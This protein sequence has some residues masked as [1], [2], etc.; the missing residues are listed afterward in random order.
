M[1]IFYSIFTFIIKKLFFTFVFFYI[2]SSNIYSQNQNLVDSLESIYTTGNFDEPD[3]LKI[4][5]ELSKNHFDP[6]KRIIYSE[7][8]IKTARNTDSLNY[9]FN[10][11]LQKGNAYR[12][13]GD[14]KKA[15]VDY[16]NAAKMA[17]DQN[18]NRDLGLI[19]ITIADVYSVMGNHNNAIHYYQKAIAILKEGKDSLDLATALYNS[20]DEYVIIKK[21]DSAL[22]YF[23]QS[24]YIFKKKKDLMGSAYNLGSIGM[25][26]AEKGNYNLAKQNINQAI[27]IL[28]DLKIYSPI[29]EFLGYMSDI[30]KDQN[31]LK[32]AFSY[33]NRSLKIAKKY[34][35]KKEIS[36]AC[37]KMSELYELDGNSSESLKY[38]KNYIAYRDSINNIESIRQMADMRTNFEVQKKQDEIYFLEKEAEI[39]QLKANKN[40]TMTYVSVIVTILV[41]LL[42]LGLLRRYLFIKKTNQI[43]QKETNKSEKLLLNILPEETALELKQN[44]KVQAK[45]FGSV[46]VMFTDFKEF[47]R[48]S[49]NL[50]PEEL[51]KS[52]DYYFS[53][54]DSIIEKYGLEKI[55]TIGDAYMCAGGLPFP[56][57]DHADK[58]IQAAFEI[59]EFMDDVK[60]K[61]LE[62]I[63]TF[64][65][66][67]GINSGPVVAGVVGTKKFAYDIW[68]DTVNVASR[69]ESTSSSGKINISETT[70]TLIKDKYDCEFRGEIQVKNKGKMKMYFVN[71]VK[72]ENL[73]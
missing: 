11:Y 18:S 7:E 46:T 26:H 6:E 43:I 41:L 25:I 69:M 17:M 47:T 28:E 61:N 56:T 21:F 29:P 37:L 54:F 5:K 73:K 23:E 9:M 1:K 31:D 39:N 57:T 52:V 12:D 58:M 16:F 32:S 33:S 2:F 3:R 8:L 30:Y 72:T 38:Y 64:D 22:V 20:G 19:N 15:L 55:K 65:I 10:G 67:I 66:R 50:S 49:H 62:N 68:G 53:K 44:G 71:N 14:Y 35:L 4:I 63:K 36:D 45:Q 40:K 70:H 27:K 42:A 24:S 60:N 13:L 59:A 34:K 48:Y 51:V